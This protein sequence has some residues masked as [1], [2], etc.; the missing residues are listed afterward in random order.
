MY[1]EYDASGWFSLA[2]GAVVMNHPLDNDYTSLNFD[3]S[4]YTISLT[5]YHTDKGADD[6]DYAKTVTITQ[7]PAIF[8]TAQ[9]NSDPKVIPPGRTEPYPDEQE[10]APGKISQ[11]YAH[12]GYVFIDG[13]RI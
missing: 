8:I 4:P 5:I 10:N 2:G 6:P 7:N 13:Q 11:N 1:L 3:Y 9:E 12:N